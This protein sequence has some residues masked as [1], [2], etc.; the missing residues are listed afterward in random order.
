MSRT[1]PA[2]ITTFFVRSIISETP[3]LS[4]TREWVK[5]C[6]SSRANARPMV[7]G[8]LTVHTMRRSPYRSASRWANRVVGTHC[9]RCRV[10]LV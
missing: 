3:M 10:G 8:F 6:I 7:D 1:R 9:E 4:Q 2:T 5:P